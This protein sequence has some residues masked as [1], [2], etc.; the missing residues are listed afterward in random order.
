MK[1]KIILLS[2][3]V[4]LFAGAVS[5]QEL[6][7]FSAMTKISTDGPSRV[8]LSF[9]VESFSGEIK[10]PV[11]YEISRLSYDSNFGKFSCSSKAQIY[12]TEITCALPQDVSGSF[13][14]EFDVYEG[15]KGSQALNVT[16]II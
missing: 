3:L 10:I 16:P 2:A 15:S 6:E 7:D 11:S 12:G 4:L 8:S 5:A 9:S 1:M 14:V 13:K